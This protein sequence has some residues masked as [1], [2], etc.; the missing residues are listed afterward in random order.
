MRN[1]K[2]SSQDCCRWLSSVAWNRPLPQEYPVFLSLQWGTQFR[3]VLILPWLHGPD[4]L[5]GCHFEASMSSPVHSWVF[6]HVAHTTPLMTRNHHSITTIQ[7]TDSSCLKLISFN[8]SMF[9]SVLF[10]LGESNCQLRKLIRVWKISSCS[11]FPLA[12][13][14][15]VIFLKWW[16]RHTCWK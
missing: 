15:I 9:C 12:C 16:C 8:F 13:V 10:S 7:S 14:L 5:T 11:F 2:S 6:Y 3:A 4:D 1:K